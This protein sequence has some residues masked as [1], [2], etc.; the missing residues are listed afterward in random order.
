MSQPYIHIPFKGSYS[1]RVLF[2]EPESNY[3]APLRC[4]L[5]E[6]PL[7]PAPEYSALSY[8][9]DAQHPSCPVQCNG[10]VLRVTPNCESALRRLRHGQDVQKLWIDSICIYSYRTATK[11]CRNLRFRPLFCEGFDSNPQKPVR[12]LGAPLG[13]AFSCQLHPPT[14]FS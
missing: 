11:C 2:L 13:L 10:G 1:I 7:E 4:S 3:A 12:A 5:A 9:W 6:L 8:A 14:R